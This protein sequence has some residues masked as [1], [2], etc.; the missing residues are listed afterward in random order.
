[1]NDQ[2]KDF[3]K[4]TGKELETFAE[5][6]RADERKAILKVVNA[7]EGMEV[8]RHAMFSEGYDYALYHIRQ[9][10]AGRSNA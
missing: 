2:I 4:R 3:T 5:L 9:V 7:L 6:V 10:I 8:D 1:M